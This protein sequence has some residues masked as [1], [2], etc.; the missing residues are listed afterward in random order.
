MPMR[1][2]DLYVVLA[3]RDDIVEEI[4]EL[5]RRKLAGDELDRGPRIPALSRFVEE[6]I[7]RLSSVQLER[8]G[9][10]PGFEDLNALFRRVL[11]AAW[12]VA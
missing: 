9:A 2:S 3:G 10:K 6:E 12:C 4:Q 7:S 11:D 5:V 1:F 8:P